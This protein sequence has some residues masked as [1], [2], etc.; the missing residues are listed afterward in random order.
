MLSL[1]G[2]RH[3]RIASTRRGPRRDEQEHKLDLASHPRSRSGVQTLAP[4]RGR[5]LREAAHA[6][7]IAALEIVHG[8]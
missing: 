4:T 6:A 2:A 3:M 8:Y 1:N 7:V 5:T